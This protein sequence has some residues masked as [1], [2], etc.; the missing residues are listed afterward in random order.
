MDTKKW[1]PGGWVFLHTIAFNYPE[2]P[3]NE[4]KMY[5]LNFFKSIGYVL[6]CIYCRN[7]FIQF[8]DKHPI[9][10]YLGSRYQVAYWLYM[11][12]NMVNE[13]LRKQEAERMQKG[14]F[15]L[16]LTPP[17][18]SFEEVCKKYNRFRAGCSDTTMT[19]SALPPAFEK[20]WWKD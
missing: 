10:P 20:R 5:Y 16:K 9:E 7:S 19:C 8:I 3:T 6:P 18:P 13:K 1:G 17:D 14:E 2:E 4:I 11:I 15:I 12:H